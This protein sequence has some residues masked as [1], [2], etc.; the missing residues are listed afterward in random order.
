LFAFLSAYAGVIEDG[1][2]FC[3]LTMIESVRFTKD[4]A[5][6]KDGKLPFAANWVVA[7]KD[8]YKGFRKLVIRVE[9][10]RGGLSSSYHLGN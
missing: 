4:R 2:L 6:A 10:G 9:S 3:K 8:E 5:T 1:S 7:L